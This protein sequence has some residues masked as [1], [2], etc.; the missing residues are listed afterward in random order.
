MGLQDD[1]R[2]FDDVTGTPADT[3]FAPARRCTRAEVEAD[4]AALVRT[5]LFQAVLDATGSSVL[6]LNRERQILVGNAVLLR[7]FGV[8]DS[9]AVRGMR[10]GE[11]FGCIHAWKNPGGCG[12]AEEC[13][14]CGAVLAVLESQ[15]TRACVERECLLTI[16]RDGR[17]EARELHVRASQL[18]IGGRDYTVVGLRDIGDER[19]RAALE[20]VFLHD[21][22]NTVGALVNLSQVLAAGAPR[23]LDEATRRLARLTHRLRREIED[24]RTLVQAENGT[25]EVVR[26]P[27]RPE[28]VLAAAADLL[29]E[30]P[31]ARDRTIAIE[32]GRA[33][34]LVVTD[35]SLL[36]RIVVN[37]MTNALE[38]TPPGGA[39]RAWAEP[40]FGS[41]A[42]SV[43]NA[44]H[45]EPRDTL[46]IFKRSFSTKP[47]R[48]RGLGTFSMKLFGERYLG[49]VVDFTTDP[50][51]G[52]TFTIR[53]P[54]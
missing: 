10:P 12:T 40:A 38:A 44:C 49:G 2:V 43:W 4:V 1:H 42:L 52:T 53:L 41:C 51:A 47:G 25:L 28:S 36:L 14:V 7:S 26:T 20:R 13:S 6:V 11:A 31:A 32:D 16:R 50:G 18:V 34:E 48:G 39:V 46:Q 3:A 27:V 8:S 45:I 35:E 54:A 22:S 23:E 37:M 9:C 24:Q 17:L 19:R 33:A 30:H 21:I 29:A 5:D 15:R